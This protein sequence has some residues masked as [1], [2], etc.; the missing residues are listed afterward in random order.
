MLRETPK[1]EFYGALRPGQNCNTSK[2]ILHVKNIFRGIAKIAWSYSL[3]Q[4]FPLFGRLRILSHFLDSEIHY[5]KQGVDH[6]K[7]KGP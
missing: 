7:I 2:N 4:T 5:K 6:A 1:I 3:H